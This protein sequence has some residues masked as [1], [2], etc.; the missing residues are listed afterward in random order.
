MNGCAEIV[1]PAVTLERLENERCNNIH[2]NLIEI[3]IFFFH[4]ASNVQISAINRVRINGSDAL[5][6]AIILE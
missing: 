2:N 1:L 3:A 6:N 4:F 5:K